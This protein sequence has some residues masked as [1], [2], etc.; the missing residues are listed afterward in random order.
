MYY[1]FQKKTTFSITSF[2]LMCSWGG[3]RGERGEKGERGEGREGREGGGEGGEGRE[4]G[5]GKGSGGMPPPT[6][7]KEIFSNNMV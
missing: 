1:S 4:G 3:E 2:L 7:S 5:E 6:P